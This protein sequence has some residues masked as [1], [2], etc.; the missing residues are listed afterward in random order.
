MKYK[1]RDVYRRDVYLLT[2]KRGLDILVYLSIYGRRG[3]YIKGYFHFSK[4][5]WMGGASPM[6]GV[7]GAFIGVFFKNE[8]FFFKNNYLLF[9]CFSVSLFRCS[10]TPRKMFV[11]FCECC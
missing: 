1:K 11:K 5:F 4:V 7:V 2:Y 10:G 6:T 8:F 3:V 9:R